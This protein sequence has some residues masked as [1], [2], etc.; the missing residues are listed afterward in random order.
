V[1]EQLIICGNQSINRENN[2]INV[3]LYQWGSINDQA[4]ESGFNQ[5]NNKLNE[6]A[7]VQLQTDTFSKKMSDFDM[8]PDFAMELLTKLSEKSYVAVFSFD[9]FP[10][11]S[12]ICQIKEIKYISWVYDAPHKTLYSKTVPYKGNYIFVVHLHCKF[13]NISLCL[14][15]TCHT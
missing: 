5:L 13:I 14:R 9:Y 12:S 1:F 15:P 4:L 8:D 6:E 10:L 2:M 7:Y 11:I 3:L